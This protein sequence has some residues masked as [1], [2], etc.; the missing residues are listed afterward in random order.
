LEFSFF[1]F[2]CCFGCSYKLGRCGRI[3]VLIIFHIWTVL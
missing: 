2:F 1:F 3:H